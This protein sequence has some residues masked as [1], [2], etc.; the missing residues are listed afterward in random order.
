MLAFIVDKNIAGLA[1]VTGGHFYSDETIWSNGLFPF[2]IP[3][4]FIYVLDIKDRV[5]I[6]GQVRDTIMRAWGTHYGWGILNKKVLPE[7]AARTIV[8]EI[9][10]RP[11]ALAVFQKEQLDRIKREKL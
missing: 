5:P 6:L 2:R 1:E 10:S 4:E 8:N 9:Q 3:I 7:D 11:N